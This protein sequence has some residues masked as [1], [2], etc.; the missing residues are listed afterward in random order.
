MGS[1]IG[2]L[3]RGKSEEVTN[4]TD[5]S[6]DEEDGNSDL[7]NSAMK[8]PD[9]PSPE[10]SYW[11]TPEITA[12]QLKSQQIMSLID[13]RSPNVSISRTPI[14][15]DEE[16]DVGKIRKNR[17]LRINQAAN[18]SGGEYTT[19]TGQIPTAFDPRSPTSEI[20]RTPIAPEEKK[21]VRGMPTFVKIGDTSE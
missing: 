13:P 16:K 3:R 4:N 1:T 5:R 10:V 9:E 21:E 2:T 19:P 8:T 20:V 11:Q 7:E 6:M 15:V 17:F 12:A 18:Q 14:M